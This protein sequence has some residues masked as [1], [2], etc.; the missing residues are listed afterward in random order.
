M[1]CMTE[2]LAI[3]QGEHIATE[4]HAPT[5]PGADSFAPSAVRAQL[6]RILNSR[7]FARSPRISRFL[8]FVVEETLQGQEDKLKEYLLGV[9]VFG[10]TESF[11][12]R[13]DSIVRVEARRL[14]Y[15]LERYY[16]TEGR[17][18]TVLIQLRK[19][20]YV[21]TFTRKRSGAGGADEEVSD[22]PY[23][24]AIDNAHAF[25]LYAKGRWNLERWTADGVA[26]S[27]SCFT[28]ALEEDP[29][30]ASAQAGLASAWTLAG[31]LGVMAGRD[32]LPKAKSAAHRALVIDPDC[33]EAHTALGMTA[34]LQDWNWP[35]SENHLRRAIHLNPCDVQARVSY[36]LFLIFTGR[37]NDAV[38]EARR[39]QQAAPTI[40]STHLAVGLACHAGGAYD[41]AL[42]QYRLAQEL[43]PSS[44]AAFL[45]TGILLADQQV[46]EQA[47]NAL[48]RARQMNAGGAA[49][50]AALAYAHAGAGR[51]D[52][53][54]QLAGELESASAH[55]YVPALARAFAASAIG[56]IATA[57]KKL[58][59]AAEERSPWLPLARFSQAFA[60]VRATD[61]YARLAERLHWAQASAE[62]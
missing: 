54:R 44:F 47:I 17:E 20:C 19:G 50:T 62:A 45:A 23:V 6:D 60:P 31:F 39:A 59:E 33:A 21:P 42:L 16:D 7:A 35:E 13:I 1:C 40:L 34:A 36:S 15:K 8:T 29:D 2:V 49:A 24:R 57:A 30:C 38:R 53:A 41:E 58:E 9:E 27:I 32:V 51:F 61:E 18:D 26:E 52:Q 11:D 12:P 48:H 10:R 22:V 14:R 46:F 37:F 3:K 56:D 4:E 55:R 43:E 5:A 28:H 25:A